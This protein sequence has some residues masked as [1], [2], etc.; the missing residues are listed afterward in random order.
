[1][2]SEPRTALCNALSKIVASESLLTEPEELTPYEC[3]GLTALREVPL[4]VVLPEN[5]DQLRA[6]VALCNQMQVAVVTR[7]AGTGLSG[8]AR[9]SK[10][11]L[12]IG[13]AKLNR[14]L[15]INSDRKSITVEPGV[16]NLAI[17][18]A[19]SHLNL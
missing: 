7:G 3:D 15:K 1:M 10:D 6:I 18:Q 17:S 2:N 19:V 16:T 14:I 8:G 9:P 4:A 13:L 5:L 11:A 12:L